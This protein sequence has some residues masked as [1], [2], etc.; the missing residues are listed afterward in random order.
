MA[1]RQSRTEAVI[2]DEVMAFLRKIIGRGPDRIHTYM[3]D[4]LAVVRCC[5]VLTVFERRLVDTVQGRNTVKD[6][7]EQVFRSGA[8]ELSGRL[9][10]CTGRR[11]L[12]V[13]SSISPERDEW[14]YVI[15]F[16]DGLAE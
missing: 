7:R 3:I 13:H 8:E 12:Y 10:G 15:E 14:V 9:E 16:E 6:L 11:V 4:A 2:S 5:G 1:H